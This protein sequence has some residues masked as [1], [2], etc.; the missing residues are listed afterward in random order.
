MPQVTSHSMFNMLPLVSSGFCAT[1]YITKVNKKVKL[2]LPV[3]ALQ[4]THCET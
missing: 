4:W 3:E 2:N 1:L